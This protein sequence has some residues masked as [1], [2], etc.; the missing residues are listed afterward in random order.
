MKN[1]NFF[2]GFQWAVPESFSDAVNLCNFEEGDIFYD[3]KSPYLDDWSTACQKI[4]HSIQ[5]K[6]AYSGS[7]PA[8][9]SDAQQFSVNWGAEVCLDLFLKQKRTSPGQIH[10]TQGRLY[11]AL[12]RG[13]LKILDSAVPAPVP[14]IRLRD[15]GKSI[16]K[17]SDAISQYADGGVAF[18]MMY[19]R[20]SPVSRSKFNK[21]VG[22]LDDVM[23]GDPVLVNPYLVDFDSVDMF[24]PTIVLAIFR[25]DRMS[26][27]DLHESIKKAV[28]VPAKDAKRDMFR[29]SAH[30]IIVSA[31]T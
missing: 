25:V 28:Y 26:C 4:G 19:D 22:V 18:A 20:S 2:D 3:N 16:I 14:P 29:I 5:V 30:G 7:L 23:I 11:T 17:V 6:A 27:H 31:A 15:A 24:A 10:T 9:A 21:I 13:D 1:I 8:G 12:W